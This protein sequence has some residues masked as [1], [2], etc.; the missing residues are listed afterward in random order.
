MFKILMI[1]QLCWWLVL[2]IYNKIP[3]SW[4]YIIKMNSVCKIMSFVSS[5]INFL[6]TQSLGNKIVIVDDNKIITWKE[7][8]ITSDNKTYNDSN[9][10]VIRRN[11]IVTNNSLESTI[12]VTFSNIIK[13]SVNFIFIL[14]LKFYF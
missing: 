11:F 14:N 9:N 7:K 4:I 5:I 6:I 1:D 10:T 8:I 13:I 3:L 2:I 12:I